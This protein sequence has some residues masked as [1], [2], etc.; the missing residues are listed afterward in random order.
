MTA[1]DRHTEEPVRDR[2][3]H[4]PGEPGVW[5]LLLGDMSVFLVL[6][7][8]YIH[9]RNQQP[10]LFAAAQHEL[11]SDLGAIN[12]LLLL[13]SSLLVVWATMCM[14]RGQRELGTRFLVGAMA[15]GAAFVGVKMFEYHEQ[16]A[17]GHSPSTN[18]F[19]TY[20]FMLTGIH[21]AHLII[22]LVVLGGLLHLM[23]RP[24]SQ[25]VPETF[26]EGGACFWHVVDLL[27][28]VIFPLIFLVH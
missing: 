12:T 11:N 6:F 24:A 4:V 17:H 7:G 21:L 27:W 13:A 16:I 8:V 23:K 14:R 5:L 28:I 1:V 15:L 18:Q 20:Y 19:F 26:F 22:G 2:R 10:Q 25:D 9:A 3:D